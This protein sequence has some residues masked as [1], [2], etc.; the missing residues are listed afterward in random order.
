MMQITV[1]PAGLSQEQREAVA[2]FILAYPQKSAALAAAAAPK[3]D[4]TGV[5]TRE[6]IA[7]AAEDMAAARVIPI[8]PAVDNSPEMAFGKAAAPLPP[9]AAVAP[10]APVAQPL[11]AVTE[12]P[13]APVPPAP[14]TGTPGVE[15]DKGG[16]P[17]DS[18]I[19]AESKAKNA[20][21]T[22]RKRRN[23][24]PATLAAVEAELRA[25]MAAPTA[26]HA[27]SAIPS[28]EVNAA[29]MALAAPSP[30]PAQPAATATMP[31]AG[32]A[33]SVAPAPVPPPPPVPANSPA[34]QQPQAPDIGQ[35]IALVG[36]ASAAVQANKLTQ[37]EI[38]EACAAVGI[39]ALPML[40]NRLDLVP[41]VAA[42]IDAI[43]AARS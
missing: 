11:A 42:T 14:V 18:R 33:S 13:T 30:T 29:A 7:G 6:E 3:P 2:G 40:A 35:Y 32:P 17:W 22:W 8:T 16:L 28:H 25:V 26:V 9:G 27:P 19:H 37:A 24:D 10:P 15:V 21:G 43:V 4:D 12:Q 41:A 1:D 31:T 34:L 5:F 20:D 36:R 39:P 23:L 38:T